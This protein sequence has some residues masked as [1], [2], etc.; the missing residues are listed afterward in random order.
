MPSRG[1]KSHQASIKRTD[2]VTAGLLDAALDEARGHK[3]KL[4]PGCRQELEAL[5]G[6][7]VMKELRAVAARDDPSRMPLA[8]D[9]VRILIRAMVRFERVN[10]MSADGFPAGPFDVVLCR[11]VLIYFDASSKQRMIERLLGRLEPGGHLFLG[12]A[13]G[14]GRT[15]G[16]RPVRPNVYALAAA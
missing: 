2:E 7:S 3:M 13:E 5:V 8:E 12:H 1:K 11:N 4:E 15:T 16:V 6:K 14:L 10:L 9:H